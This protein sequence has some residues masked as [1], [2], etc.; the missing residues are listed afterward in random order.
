MKQGNRVL[1]IWALA[2]LLLAG[3]QAFAQSG[4]K[5]AAKTPKSQAAQPAQPSD[6]DLNIRAYIELLR[7]DL[8]AEATAVVGQVMQLDD[9]EAAKFWPIY[10]EYEL[11]FGK[12]GDERVELIK[13][14]VE[15]YQNITDEL[16][17]QLVQGVFR[18]EQ[19][20]H[21][22]KM[23]YY[24]RMKKELSARTAARFVQVQ[25]QILMLIDLQVSAALP[26][27]K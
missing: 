17:D 25:N 22:L 16:A 18:Q 2:A 14:Y 24:E 9:D 13:K 23:K 7:S 21:N 4:S 8:K 11:D 1:E 10:R 5:P 12:L 15:N 19:Q 3:G 20:R 6:R 27:A 26:V